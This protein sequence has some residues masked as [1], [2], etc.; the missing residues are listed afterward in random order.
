MTNPSP[1]RRC[2]ER[3]PRPGQPVGAGAGIDMLQDPAQLLGL[4]LTLQTEP[5]RPSTDPLP[6]GL[7]GAGVVLLGAAGDGV[8]V[9]L[10]LAR[11][12][13]PQA[14]RSDEHTS[15]LQS[16]MRISYAVFCFK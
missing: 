10:L 8:E 7:P 1:T 6:G 11:G 16:L 9:V 5:S 2:A 4:D 13:L 14:Q 15:E 12:Q 3:R